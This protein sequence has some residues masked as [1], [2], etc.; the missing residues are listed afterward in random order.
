MHF[1]RRKR[2]FCWDGIGFEICTTI[3]AWG[4]EGRMYKYRCTIQL[5]VQFKSWQFESTTNRWWRYADEK[6]YGTYSYNITICMTDQFIQSVCIS[7]PR[8]AQHLILKS[9]T[10]PIIRRT[11]N[12]TSFPHP[13]LLRWGESHP[14]TKRNDKPESWE[15]RHKKEEV[16]WQTR[17]QENDDKRPHFLIVAPDPMKLCCKWLRRWMIPVQKT[18]LI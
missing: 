16:K 13:P 14:K 18:A 15:D 6:D 5:Q 10:L 2:C 11:P 17:N 8:S 1:G 3:P 4:I 7:L 9:T 12:A